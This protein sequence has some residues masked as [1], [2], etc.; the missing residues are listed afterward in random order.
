M[1][2]SGYW[3]SFGGTGG[4]LCPLFSIQANLLKSS[5]QKKSHGYGF[6]NGSWKNPQPFR[7]KYDAPIDLENGMFDDWK[8]IKNILPNLQW[9]IGVLQNGHNPYKNHLKQKTNPSSKYLECQVSYFLGN[10][11]PL[12]PATRLP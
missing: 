2:W 11:K 6:S 9:K 3:F 1:V 8:R 4:V 5:Y 10:V 7:N 12:K